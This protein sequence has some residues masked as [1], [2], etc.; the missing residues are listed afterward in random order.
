MTMYGNS[1]ITPVHGCH[2]NFIF[3]YWL[4]EWL[5]VKD[6]LCVDVLCVFTLASLVPRF[7]L[8]AVELRD[9]IWEWPGDEATEQ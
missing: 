6:T 4:F 8:A 5:W 2:G 3:Y 1:K 9:K 7:Y